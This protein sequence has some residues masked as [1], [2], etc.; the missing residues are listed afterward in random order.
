M[1]KGLLGSALVFLA[2]TSAAIGQTAPTPSTSQAPPGVGGGK[3]GSPEQ[4]SSAFVTATPGIIEPIEIGGVPEAS[5]AWGANAGR[6]LQFWA[7]AE[8]LLWWTKAGSTPPLVTTGPA[9]PLAPSPG[10]FAAP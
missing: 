6:P 8:Y 2:L 5:A 1:R 10:S 7:S 9:L 3:L 4:A